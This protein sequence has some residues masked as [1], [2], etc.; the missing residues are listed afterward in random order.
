VQER[1][2]L[3]VEVLPILGEPSAAIEPGDGAL[4]DPAFGQHRSTANPLT[5]SERLTIS[6]SRCGR[7]F[8]SAFANDESS[9]IAILNVGRMNGGVEQQT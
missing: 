2:R 4:H 1:E 7:T 5:R 8:A 6:T 9:A 3:S